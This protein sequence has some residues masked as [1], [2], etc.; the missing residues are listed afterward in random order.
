MANHRRWIALLGA[1][2]M[3]AALA[4]GAGLATAKVEL[5]EVELTYPTEAVV[6]AVK[7]ATVAAQ[8][9][10][11]VV[12]VR[13]D[14][15]D[16]VRQ[17][18]V[19]MR[20]DE[21][22]AAQAVAGADAQLAQAQANLANAKATYER[23]RNLLAQKFVSQAA[24]DQAESTWRAAEAQV[25]AA[26]AGKGQ[27]GTVKAYTTVTSPLT[28][29]VAHRHA[30][31]GEMASPGKELIT[32]FEPGDLRVVAT[33]PQYKLAEVKHTLR[34]RVELPE[35]KRWI[36]AASVTVLPTADSRT[37]SVRVR[38]D[39]PDDVQG[40]VPGMYARAHFFTGK[41]RKLV[42]P[43]QAV[44]RRGEV[45]AVYAI[46]DKGGLQMRQVRLGEPVA[47]EAVEVLAGLSAGER[48]ALDPVK[49]GMQLAQL[50]A[51]Q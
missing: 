46:D 24:L 10:G 3:P 28:G 14:A 40:V 26:A 29:I 39:L 51:K 45:S 17:G 1:L 2:W 15:G 9:Q 35:S 47:G 34:A 6:E 5:R 11:R 49:A 50:N 32:V 20:I 18:D 30:E 4:Q 16:R 38:I 42:V 37:H 48:V 21:R 31:L 7:Q 43:S 13:A 12:E 25:R 36:D 8:V 22:E 41:A 44:L 33:V 23:T 19:L 27:A